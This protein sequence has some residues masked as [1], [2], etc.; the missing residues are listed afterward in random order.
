M[1]EAGGGF[2]GRQIRLRGC[3]RRRRGT[4]RTGTDPGNH[5]RTTAGPGEP[6]ADRRRPGGTGAARHPDMAAS[7]AASSAR[8]DMEELTSVRVYSC[9]GAS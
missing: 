5:T 3:G 9:L 7:R 8:S 4:L 6:H 2:K 1:L